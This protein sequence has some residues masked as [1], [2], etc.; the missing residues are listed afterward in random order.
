MRQDGFKSRYAIKVA[1]SVVIAVIN[2]VIQFILPRVLS[3]EEYGYYSYNLNVFASV[4]LIATLATPNALV[5]K[6]SKRNEEIGLVYFYLKFFFVAT[7]I[8][9]IGIVLLFPL[10]N[11]RNSFGGQTFYTIILALESSIVSKLLTDSI[12]LYDSMA[13]SR[14][15]AI[16]QIVMKTMI[17]VV[18]LCGYLFNRISLLFF[19]V[20]Q[21]II[22]LI[23]AV[24]MLKML[25]VEQRNNYPIIIDKGMVVYI[26]EY[27][28]YCRPLV[29]S[30]LISQLTII[31]M[32]WTLMKYSGASEQALFG[33]AWQL[34]TLV[35]YVFSPYAELSK[36]EF[37][38]LHN[39]TGMLKRRY[40]QS[41]RIVMWMT[42]YFAI[43]IGICAPWILPIVY[44]EKYSG[45]A[46]ITLLIMYY[47][48]YQ[49]WGQVSGSFMLALEKTRLS[50]ALSV[51]AQ[52]LTM[53]AVFM[54]QIPNFIWPKGLGA[55]GI[56][57]NYLTVNISVVLLSLYFV[58]RSLKIR[59][60]DSFSIQLLPMLLCSAT[61]MGLKVFCDYIMPGNETLI[62]LTKLLI[63][64]GVYTTVIA[65]TI[66]SNPELMG[67]SREVIVRTLKKIK[68]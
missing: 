21:T 43:F 35:S 44:G 60:C 11:I 3:V 48:V 64:G 1:S 29:I 52:L 37:A 46:D 56:A 32:N 33:A 15:P 36:R 68:G 34:N 28:E 4:V 40:L 67:T 6:F 19:Y 24:I 27:F 59:Y 17:C 8:L 38:V 66:W 55:L 65:L 58:G 5:A 10:P 63:S 16:L 25:I 31:V 14:F 23:I 30:N 62:L 2:A 9:N 57:L 41:L 20:A 22:I 18:V 13:I 12:S 7:I 26:R 54:F 50:A 45:A 53:C 61:S 39:D 51:I 49:A 47:T 42:A